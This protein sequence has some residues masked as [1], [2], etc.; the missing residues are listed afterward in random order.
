MD[1]RTFLFSTFGLAA[2]P[3]PSPW[4]TS[5]G[6]ALAP[7]PPDPFDAWRLSFI[8]KAAAAGWPR[9][10]VGELMAPLT[11]DDRVV[12]ADR[13]QPEF[14]RPVGDY[15]DGMVAAT[16]VDQGRARRVEM[17]HTLRRITDRTGVPPEILV[18]I[19]GVESNFGRNQGDYDVIRSLA[20][21][22]AD[23]RR[24]EWAEGQLLAALR[25]LFSGEAPR[26]RLRGSWAGAMGQTQF[27]PDTF[28]AFAVD[29]DGDGR[30]DIW[31]SAADALGSAGNYLERRGAWRRGQGW[32]REVSLPPGFDYSVAEGP[33]RVWAE[34]SAQGVRTADG[35]DWNAAEA[36]ESAVLIVPAGWSGPAFLT[37]P[38][39]RAIRTYN[40]STSYALAVGLLAE[41]IAG[42][43]RLSKAWP[44]DQPLSLEDRIAAQEALA[45]LGFDPGG[46]DGIMGTRTRA[47]AREWQKA[48]GL[49]ADGHLSYG[50][51]QALKIQAGI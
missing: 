24:R 33:G 37:L 2:I 34:W 44:A 47:A 29:E 51:I 41:R 11:P 3:E 35:L 14:S 36:G 23:G 48:R 20:T 21:L 18:S 31:G 30:R 27:M 9:A 19:W 15:I 49:P 1:R 4:D 42:G 45:R 28:L 17:T 16:R 8:E 22:A 39:H 6:A 10:R 26:D 7:A 13:R 25:I 50:L 43:G 38:N 12:N 32:A 46:A 5:L 40:N